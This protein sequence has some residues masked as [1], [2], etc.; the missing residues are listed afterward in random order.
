MVFGNMDK[1][2]I[3][4]MLLNEDLEEEVICNRCFEKQEFYEGEVLQPL[5][6]NNL[7]FEFKDEDE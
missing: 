7:Y 2:E 3:C 5:D 6:F 4:G 1:C